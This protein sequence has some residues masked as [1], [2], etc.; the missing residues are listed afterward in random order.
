MNW[1]AIGAVGELIGAIA[2][3]I[4][5]VYLAFQI[6]VMRDMNEKLAIDSTY[7]KFNAVRQ[8]VFENPELASLFS[9]W[10]QQSR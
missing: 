5:L 4:T 7:S 2:I 3:L 9:K 8:S 10:S 6:K 1:D